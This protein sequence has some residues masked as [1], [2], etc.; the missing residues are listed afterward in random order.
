MFQ[1]GRAAVRQIAQIP[2]VPRPSFCAKRRKN[3]FDGNFCKKHLQSSKIVVY[4]NQKAV[5]PLDAMQ[6]RNPAST[7]KTKANP[8]RARDCVF[9]ATGAKVDLNIVAD[10]KLL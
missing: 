9:C 5:N 7:L 3:F 4:Y 1:A 6:G 8:N 2:Q 10:C